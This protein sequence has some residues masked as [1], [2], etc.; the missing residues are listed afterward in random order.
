M[1]FSQTCGA[2]LVA[3]VGAHAQLVATP[4]YDAPYCDGPTYA[5]AIVTR[6]GT[7][8]SGVETL[9]SARVAVNDLGSLSGWWLLRAAGPAPAERVMTG[10]HRLSARAVAAGDADAAAIDAVAWAYLQDFEPETAD[11][12]AVIAVT[13]SAPALPFITAA[14]R[15]PAERDALRGALLDVLGASAKTSSALAE[16]LA[17]L[18]LNGVQVLTAADYAPLAALRPAD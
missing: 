1:L 16:A 15:S 11:A 2:P 14:H 3:G 17:A 4:I 10:A 8:W 9:G 5:S 12:L 18:R 13:P 6:R 7:R